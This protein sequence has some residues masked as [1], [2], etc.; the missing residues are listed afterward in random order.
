MVIEQTGSPFHSHSHA[1][2]VVAVMLAVVVVVAAAA[3]VIITENNI[4]WEIFVTSCDD[5]SSNGS[6]SDSWCGQLQGNLPIGSG[7]IMSVTVVGVVGWQCWNGF[8]VSSSKA[9]IQNA[10]D[11]TLASGISQLRRNTLLTRQWIQSCPSQF[12]RIP[13][14]YS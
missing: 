14:N 13:W 4:S 1:V 5:S 6:S 11:K 3:V 9:A 8:D 7:G 10:M 2:V 12:N